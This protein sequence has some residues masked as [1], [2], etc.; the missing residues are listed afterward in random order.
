MTAMNFSGI[1]K[2]T[3]LGRAL[4]SPFRLIPAST[5]MPILQG[6]LRGKKW[7][8]GAGDHGCWLGSYEYSTQRAFAGI[9][10]R[11]DCVYDLGANAGLYSLLASALVGAEGK[12]FSFEP[13]GLNIAYLKRHIALNRLRN[14][15]VIEAAVSDVEGEQN[16]ETGAKST[17]AHLSEGG[18]VVVRSVRLDALVENGAIA[19]PNAMKVDVEG[20]ELR[21]LEGAAGTI[22]AYRPAILLATHNAELHAACVDFLRAR[23]YRI[24]LLTRESLAGAELIARV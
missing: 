22:E 12:V 24:E 1:S 9:V 23:G 15:A 2:D 7:I 19:P 17:T 11:G 14:C 4:R 5:A 13:L 18:D 21:A 20:S 3:L 6:P 8:V 10:K 16:F